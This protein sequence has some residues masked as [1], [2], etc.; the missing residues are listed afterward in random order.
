VVW[1]GLACLGLAWLGLAWP[2][3]AWPGLAWWCGRGGD[4]VSGWVGFRQAKRLQKC[5]GTSSSGASANAEAN[6][7]DVK[8]RFIPCSLSSPFFW[9]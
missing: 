2:G 8:V 4:G 6:V 3:L 5:E 1:P 9:K 7:S